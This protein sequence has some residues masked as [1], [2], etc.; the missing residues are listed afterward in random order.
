MKK[1][2]NVLL[3]FFFLAGCALLLYPTISDY[4]NK[5][6][7]TQAVARYADY[8]AN[9]V[10]EEALQEALD[11]AAAYNEALLQS[12]DQGTY[13]K[14][15]QAEYESLLNIDGTSIMGYVDI[16]SI[17]T[18]LPIYHG[19][20]ESVLQ[21][22]VGH[23]E[24][25]SLPVGGEGTHTVLS[26]HRGL[27]S[28][29]L[30][31]DLDQM[32]LGDIFTVHVY[33]ET[34]YYQVDDISVVL[35]EE[36]EGLQAEEGEDYCTLITCTPYGVNTHR[37]LVRGT[38]IYPDFSTG[39]IFTDGEEVSGVLV[40]GVLSGCLIIVILLIRRRGKRRRRKKHE[41]VEG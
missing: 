3:V 31:T 7:Q 11:A 38:R 14:E 36:A 40:S 23:L 29:R 4:S 21:V 16:P 6:H 27:P 12:S 15:H 28:A 18:T 17:T 24:W 8:V 9:E 34:L 2:L 30:F 37:L 41:A 25:T 5:M 13:Y 10:D 19:T 33:N 1:L 26:G 35:P 22:A 20:E 39:D 32:T